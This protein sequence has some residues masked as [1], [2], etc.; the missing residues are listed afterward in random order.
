MKGDVLSALKAVVCFI[1]TDSVV[2]RLLSSIAPTT[3]LLINVNRKGNLFTNSEAISQDL[4]ID[5]YMYM[6]CD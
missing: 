5:M 4:K 6:S 2:F 3:V 1:S